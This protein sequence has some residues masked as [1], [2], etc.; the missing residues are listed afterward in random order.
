LSVLWLNILP[1]PATYIRKNIHVW[2]F[3][4]PEL[5]QSN[6]LFPLVTTAVVSGS[7]DKG[8]IHLVW[9]PFCNREYLSFLNV[10]CERAL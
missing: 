2:V 4:H 10:C 5:T 6:D 3:V 9:R 8:L 7:S 1:T